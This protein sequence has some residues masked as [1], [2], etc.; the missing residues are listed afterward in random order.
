M[1][2]CRVEVP[3]AGV[4][5][6]RSPQDIG[7]GYPAQKVL[8]RFVRGETLVITECIDDS[9]RHEIRNTS[10]KKVVGL[11]EISHT[12]LVCCRINVVGSIDHARFIRHF[13]LKR[14]TG[15]TPAIFGRVSTQSVSSASIRARLARTWSLTSFS[16]INLQ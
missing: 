3:R 2:E 11:H 10:I 9:K 1:A 4:A 12:H 15:R 8:Y 7:R 5:E 14:T 6:A 13:Q 16:T